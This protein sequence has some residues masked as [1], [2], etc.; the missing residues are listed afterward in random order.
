MFMSMQHVTEYT[1]GQVLE[2]LK[3]A[4]FAV[5]K[6][7]SRPQ[8]LTKPLARAARFLLTGQGCWRLQGRTTNWRPRCSISREEAVRNVPVMTATLN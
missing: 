4:G 5:P 8:V 6:V 1:V 3:Y 7:A 2:Q